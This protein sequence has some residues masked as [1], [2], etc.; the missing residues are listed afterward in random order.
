M[1]PVSLV[2]AIEEHLGVYFDDDVAA[3]KESC[4]I[5]RLGRPESPWRLCFGVREPRTLE[6]WNGLTQPWK[7]TDNH[8]LSASW[9]NP[10]YSNN[11]DWMAKCAAEGQ[12][13]WVVALVPARTDTAWWHDHVEPSAK[14]VLFLR[15][16]VQFER[17]ADEQVSAGPGQSSTFPSA[18]ILWHPGSYRSRIREG[19]DWRGA[20]VVAEG[21]EVLL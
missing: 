13:R 3:E 4:I 12:R 16:R 20:G 5:W 11:A 9:C 8:S 21:Q 10:P 17:P 6:T 18:V 1:T 2:R 19:W 7:W 15:G 14:V